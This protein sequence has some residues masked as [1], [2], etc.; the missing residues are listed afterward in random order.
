MLGR[1]NSLFE[2]NLNLEVALKYTFK[3]LACFS[4]IDHPRGQAITL[5]DLHDLNERLGLARMRGEVKK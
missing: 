2:D 1:V 3:A 5:K 4:A